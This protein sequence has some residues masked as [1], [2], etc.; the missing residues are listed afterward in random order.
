MKA[1]Q[2][3]LTSRVR[4]VVLEKVKFKPTNPVPRA[5]SAYAFY[6][7][8]QKGSPGG[9]KE[10]AQAW[11]TLPDY[12]EREG[13]GGS[14]RSAGLLLRG[15][16]GLQVC[17]LE[18]SRPESMKRKCEWCGESGAPGSRQ[19]HRVGGVRRERRVGVG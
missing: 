6:T 10:M 9:F 13:R 18:F 7:E 15:S 1:I 11:K 4:S 5:R 14:A 17:T 2:T 12:R 16:A 8:D 19:G 3:S